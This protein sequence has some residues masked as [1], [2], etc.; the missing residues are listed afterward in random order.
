MRSA[1]RKSRNKIL[2]CKGILLHFRLPW[3][4]RS[5]YSDS[6]QTPRGSCWLEWASAR[7]LA[8]VALWGCRAFRIFRNCNLVPQA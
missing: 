1:K 4:C 3:S 2:T 5:K 6:V 8:L 7:R